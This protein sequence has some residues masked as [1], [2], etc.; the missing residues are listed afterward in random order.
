MTE[1][2]DDLIRPL[3]GALD[4]H[5]ARADVP[6][7]LLRATEPLPRPPGGPRPHASWA[8]SHTTVDVPGDHW[9]MTEEHA[10]T[11]AQA[12]TAG[13]GTRLTTTVDAPA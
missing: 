10:R 13:L 3:P 9:S 7:L 11:T 1:I 6:V 8:L 5:A 2:R 4:A 12:I